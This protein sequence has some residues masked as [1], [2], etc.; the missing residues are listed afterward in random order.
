MDSSPPKSLRE[1][2]RQALLRREAKSSRRRLTVLPQSSVDFSSNDFLSLS[3]SPVFR[4]RFLELLHQAPPLYPFASGGSRLL[5]GNSTYAEELENFIAQFHSAPSGLLFNSGFD[6]NVGVFSCVPQPGDLI[7]YD[8]LIHASAREGMRLSRAGKR[9]PF[10]H[11]SPDSLDE[12]LQSHI[13]ADPLIQTGS[14]NVFVAIESIYSMDGDIAPIQDFI[15]VVD[16]LLPRGNG[17]FIVDE[18]HATGVFGPR[19]AGVVQGLGVEKRMFIRVHTFGKA[20]ASHGAIVLCCPDTR[21]Y[22]INYARSLIYT[23]AMGFPFLASIRAAYELLAAGETEQ[24]QT[25]LQQLVAY[26]RDRLAE[27]DAWDPA[28]FQVDHFPTSP[29]FSARSRFPRQLAAACQQKGF[30]VRAIMAPTV[31]AGRERVRVCLHAGNTAEEIDGLVETFKVWL[32]QTMEKK[33]ARL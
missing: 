19:G 6:A 5:D 15:R 8:E 26:F 9:V 30:V 22:L 2:L 13:A 12:V 7:V 24:H 11:S 25:K 17:Y 4:E 20:L 23:T 18:A 31:P 29:I 32:S 10:S 33:V 1:S 14:R 3:T 27:L 21:D 16:R 28:A